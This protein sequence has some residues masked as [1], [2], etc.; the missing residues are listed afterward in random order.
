MGGTGS[1]VS[2]AYAQW[3]S[4]QAMLSQAESLIQSVSGTARLWGH[5]SGVQSAERVLRAA[6]AWLALN[7]WR[8]GLRTPFA[9][10][11]DGID[12]SLSAWGFQGIFISSLLETDGVWLNDRS[13]ARFGSSAC[14]LAPAHEAGSP[15]DVA[16]RIGRAEALGLQ[17][18]TATVPAATGM[19]PDFML[20]ARRHATHQGLYCMMAIPKAFWKDLP[21]A[22]DSWDCAPLPASLTGRLAREGVIPA[23]IAQDAASGGVPSG[24]AA[25][26]EVLGTDGETRRYAY[27]WAV[28]PWRPVLLWQDP[29]GRARTL[30]AG[31]IIQTTGLQRQTLAGI[32]LAGL[33]GLDA[34]SPGEPGQSLSPAPEALADMTGQVHRY[35]GWSLLLDSASAG[36]GSLAKFLACADF[37][38]LP[39][40]AELVR[41]AFRTGSAGPLAAA[42]EALAGLGP[43]AR[44]LAFGLDDP[45]RPQSGAG[46]ALEL[47]GRDGP[48]SSEDRA[49]AALL[50]HAMAALPC[51]LPG[52]CFVSYE[53]L[54]G[55][56][57]PGDP[58]SALFPWPGPGRGGALSA[59][60]P[61]ELL[62]DVLKCRAA[63]RAAEGKIAAVAHSPSALA[64]ANQLPDGS[65]LVCAVNFSGQG[66]VQTIA[67]P[68]ACKVHTIETLTP[69][70]KGAARLQGRV[71]TISLNARQA[72]H[73]LVDAGNG[74]KGL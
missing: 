35:G 54:A 47:L 20:Q 64:C 38:A 71:L 4:R 11:L 34:G 18:G 21:K 45:E 60:Q 29:S 24:W 19:G 16:A 63:R 68:P 27:R 65:L 58:G 33:K 37:V 15:D 7:P 5:S 49:R 69:G 40:L 66:Q 26:G 48:A 31:S 56:A 14:S 17:Q 9:K 46:L 30:L 25:T 53:D 10:S 57:K 12:A 70:A 55:I 61:A 13:P 41:Q 32:S 22:A 28:S 6:P 72:V 23:G 44:R 43:E 74:R 50:V 2:P 67:I 51:A 39:E 8:A 73:V 1:R 36:D 42:L 52:L 3:L 62:A 59:P